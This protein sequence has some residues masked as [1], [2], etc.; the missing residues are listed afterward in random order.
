MRMRYCLGMSVHA[1]RRIFI[2]TT[3]S[4]RAAPLEVCGRREGREREEGE[5][6]V[7]GGRW[8][9]GGNH[10]RNQSARKA[11][12]PHVGPHLESPGD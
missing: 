9:C 5:R 2:P 11:H 7:D 1:V 8:V 10:I 12:V 4:T 6:R 3:V